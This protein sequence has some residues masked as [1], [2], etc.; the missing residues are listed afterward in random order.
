MPNN[1]VDQRKHQQYHHPS[2]EVALD[3]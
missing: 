2:K 3:K 1:I